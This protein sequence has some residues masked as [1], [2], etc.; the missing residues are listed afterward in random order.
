MSQSNLRDWLMHPL[1]TLALQGSRFAIVGM[2]ATAT[3][4]LV[5]IALVEAASVTPMAGNVL[6]FLI[7]VL[8][9]FAGHF[10]W[11]FAAPDRRG[12]AWAGAFRKFVVVALSGLALN[13]LAVYLVVDIY[14][15]YYYWA[16]AIMVTI[17]PL[18]VFLLS[19]CW[20]FR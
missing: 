5:M 16:V 11:T 1:V 7:A 15:L 14:A 13:S 17:V 9:S 20:A 10:Y 12:Q 4:V 6:G 19:K 3:H 8:V 2:A 18:V